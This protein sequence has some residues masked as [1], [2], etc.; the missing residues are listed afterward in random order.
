MWQAC[1]CTAAPRAEV[2]GRVTCA[3][4][5]LRVVQDEGVRS[6]TEVTGA[7]G[8]GEMGGVE[9]GHCQAPAVPGAPTLWPFPGSEV[10]ILALPSL[11]VSWTCYLVPL[12]LSWPRPLDMT[13]P[14]H[15]RTRVLRNGL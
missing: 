1:G 4:M 13:P 14:P 2:R 3:D 5:A 11:A 8:Q 12:C 10:P 7:L 6:H 15:E 9:E